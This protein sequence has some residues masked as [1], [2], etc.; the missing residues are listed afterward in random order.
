MD[1]DDAVDRDARLLGQQLAE[2]GGQ[3]VGQFRAPIEA[4]GGGLKEDDR[5]LVVGAMS[6]DGLDRIALRHDLTVTLRDHAGDGVKDSSVVAQRP[7]RP[8]LGYVPRRLMVREDSTQL[9]RHLIATEH[10]ASIEPDDEAIAGDRSRHLAGIA[11]VPAVDQASVE[12]SER[13]LDGHG[14]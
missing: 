4:G 6:D 2:L 3:L 8:Q 11:G 1:R 14:S 12:P 5:P 7:Y 9:G 10:L 13:F